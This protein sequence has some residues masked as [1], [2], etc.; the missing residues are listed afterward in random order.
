MLFHILPTTCFM[1]EP[2]GGPFYCFQFDMSINKAAIN[3]HL[4]VL[5]L[6]YIFISLRSILSSGIPACSGKCITF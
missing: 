6:T 1:C 2:V 3:I 4:Q 5:V